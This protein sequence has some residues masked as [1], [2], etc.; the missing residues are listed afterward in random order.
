MCH[1]PNRVEGMQE[2]LRETYAE[3]HRFYSE[4]DGID[5]ARM[6]RFVDTWLREHIASELGPQ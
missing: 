5:Y 6:G 4:E 2:A 1:P 3:M